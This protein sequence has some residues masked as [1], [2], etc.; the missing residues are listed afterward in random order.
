[1]SHLLLWDGTCGLCRRAVEWVRARDV[2]HRFDPVPYQDARDPRV[3][4]ALRTAC[5]RAVH[6]I[7]ED[8]RVL[9]AGRASLF[10]LGETGWPRAAAVLR[11]PPFVWA[12]EA[13]YRLVASNRRLF[14]RLLFRGRGRDAR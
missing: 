7:T 8:G 10:V 13:A 14:G 12:V 3:T 2:R 4:A 11:V 1:V 5:V 6:V 9:R